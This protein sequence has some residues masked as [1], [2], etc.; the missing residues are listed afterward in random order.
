M[1]EC[2]KQLN[3]M[4]V[5][6]YRSILKLEE[7]TLTKSDKFDISISDIHML[8]AIGFADEKGKTVS[9]IASRMGI[10]LPSVTVAINKLARKGFVNKSKHA[11]DGR[12]VYVSL[13]QLGVRIVK[14]H[15]RFHRQ[16]TNSILKEFTDEEKRILIRGFARMNDY[17]KKRLKS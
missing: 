7:E 9:D 3:D 13:T 10:T 2:G 14:I 5:E 1:D 8:E 11:A 6:T 12:V 16:M 15:G 4:L 17:F